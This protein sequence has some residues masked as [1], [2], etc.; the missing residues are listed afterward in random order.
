MRAGSVFRSHHDKV[1][2]VQ[3]PFAQFDSLLSIGFLVQ[4]ALL[5]D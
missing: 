1:T 5:L 3:F 2:F 4:P